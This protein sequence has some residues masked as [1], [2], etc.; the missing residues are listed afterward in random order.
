MPRA[1]ASGVVL[2][3]AVAFA[4]PARAETIDIADNYAGGT[5]SVK[6]TSGFTPVS[7]SNTW[8]Q[9]DL[10]GTES[11]YEVYGMSVTYSGNT[12]TV[13]VNSA[14][15]DNVGSDGTSMG[16]LF[17][18][19]DGYDMGA[20]TAPYKTDTHATGEDWEF[21]LVM[22]VHSGAAL[23]TVALYDIS[24]GGTIGLSTAPTGATFRAEQEVT[25]TPGSGNTALASGTWFI[26]NNG[27]PTPNDDYLTFTIDL[28]GAG[29][30]LL[31]PGSDGLGFHW[32]M[33]CGNDTIEG[34]AAVPVP[35]PGTL[36]LLGAGL[37]AGLA[38]R[39]RWRRR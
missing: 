38:G 3:A 9:K 6:T 28:S 22:N 2:L 18:S 14:Y 35:E 27:S 7:S 1:I 32:A 20:M 36:L 16:D 8:Y 39:R 12:L 29:W 25:F 26:T 30:S 5:V 31:A 11:K 24:D 17:I 13:S 37:A 23:G 10:V 34:F 4:T 33:S 21:V 19:S 15:F